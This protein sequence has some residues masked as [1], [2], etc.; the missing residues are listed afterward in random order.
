[1]HKGTRASGIAALL[2]A[3]SLCGGALAKLPPPTQQQQQAAAAKKEQA[4]E[5][6][7]KAKQELTVSMDK[8]VDLWRT[9]AAAKGWEMHSPTPVE[10]PAKQLGGAQGSTATG[11]VRSEKSGTAPPS[12][13]VKQPAKQGPPDKIQ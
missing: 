11:P 12:A 4:A 6:A 13:D 9:K 8:I 10:S 3:G 1:M 5:Q 2:L 7:K